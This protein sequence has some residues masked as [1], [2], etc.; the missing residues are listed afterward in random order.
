MCFAHRISRSYEASASSISED[1][2]VEEIVKLVAV[3]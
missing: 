1:R 3:A 2:I